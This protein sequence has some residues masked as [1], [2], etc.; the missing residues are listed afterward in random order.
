MKLTSGLEATVEVAQRLVNGRTAGRKE[1]V[2]PLPTSMNAAHPRWQSSDLEAVS[3]SVAGAGSAY[4]S[5][6]NLH[7]FP[8][9]IGDEDLNEKS[10]GADHGKETSM[11][12]SHMLTRESREDKA[13]RK[14]EGHRSR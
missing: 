8:S 12:V 11:T 3:A 9:T 10:P 14:H 5:A 7:S 2:E 4:A 6:A 13:S 1:T